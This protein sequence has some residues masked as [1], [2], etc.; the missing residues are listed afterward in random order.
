M[1]SPQ[2]PNN[3]AVR[4][5]GREGRRSRRVE[6]LYD[7]GDEQRESPLESSMVER[8]GENEERRV[9]S[10]EGDVSDRMTDGVTYQSRSFG[11][12][13]SDCLACFQ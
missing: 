12:Q 9:K 11:S 6:K 2:H 3:E 8:C 1:I 5:A 10:D 4:E 7:M 13:S